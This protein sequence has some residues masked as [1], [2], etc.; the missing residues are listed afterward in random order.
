MK[1]TWTHRW[2][3]SDLTST[4]SATWGAD[5]RV[6]LEVT[7]AH[8][9]GSLSGSVALQTPWAAARDWLA[10]TKNQYGAGKVMSSASLK[11]SLGNNNNTNQ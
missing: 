1:S 4:M 5:K 9:S 10:E 11:V 3:P 8:V 2:S 6:Q 7:G